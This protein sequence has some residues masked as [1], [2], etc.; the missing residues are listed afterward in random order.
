MHFR[1]RNWIAVCLLLALVFVFP[2]HKTLYASQATGSANVVVH[3]P[4]YGWNPLTASDADLNYYNY[5]PRPRDPAKLS[6]WASQ[7]TNAKWVR[8]EF[9][10]PEPV[11]HRL[12]L[13][14]GAD[15]PGGNAPATTF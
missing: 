11:D 15:T 5:P 12:R 8:P 2:G 10:P 13:F 4:P 14:P 9:G 3:V 1:L 7:V 6:Q